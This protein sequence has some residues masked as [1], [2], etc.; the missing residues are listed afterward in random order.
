ML[1]PVWLHAPGGTLSWP[2][3]DLKIGVG[4]SHFDPMM[5][6]EDYWAPKT[7]YSLLLSLPEL[8]LLFY[9]SE[10]AG[11][12]FRKFRV[13]H[14]TG[15]LRSWSEGVTPGGG[16]SFGSNSFGGGGGGGLMGGGAY[17][18]E[19][20][21]MPDGADQSKTW[22]WKTPSPPSHFMIFDTKYVRRPAVD[23]EKGWY[24]QNWT[25][26]C[27]DVLN[28]FEIL[29]PRDFLLWDEYCKVYEVKI[30]CKLPL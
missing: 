22:S 2:L 1:F 21:G 24:D 28:F 7:I 23:I 11:F 9:Q 18:P 25:V 20:V 3:V 13:V 4:G 10:T 26:Q 12:F 16:S 5:K 30:S 8:Y 27:A 14:C 17:G 15:Y 19:S 29:T 6:F